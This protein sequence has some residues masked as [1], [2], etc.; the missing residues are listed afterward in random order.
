MGYAIMP[1]SISAGFM[2]KWGV[3]TFLAIRAQ[4]PVPSEQTRAEDEA[5]SYEK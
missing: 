5:V 3:P 1:R 2:E 4:M